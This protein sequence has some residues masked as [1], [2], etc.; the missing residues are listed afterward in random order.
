MT[1]PSII[2]LG[3]ALLAVASWLAIKVVLFD[4]LEYVCDIFQHL[5]ISRSVFQGHPFL[6]EPQAAGRL[7]NYPILPAFYAL[8]GWLG[9][10]GLFVGLAAWLTVAIAAVWRLASRAEAWRRDLYWTVLF[11]LGLGPVG[12]WLWDDPTYGWHTQLLFLPMGIL[13]AT[14]LIRGTRLAWIMAALIVLNREEGALVAWAIHAL[15]V[16]VP[17]APDDVAGQETRWFTPRTRRLMV[18]TSVYVV[19]F[20]VNFGWLLARQPDLGDSRLGLT[21]SHAPRSL[22]TDAA[23]RGAMGS[24][25]IDVALLLLSSWL[26]T[27]AGLRPRLS[28]AV[29][30]VGPL[31]ASGMVGML[32]YPADGGAMLYHGLSWPP[33]FVMVW[34]V[35]VAAFL[36]A[37]AAAAPPFTRSRAGHVALCAAVGLASVVAQDSVLESRRGYDAVSRVTTVAWRRS[38]L[39]SSVLTLREDAMLRCLG[40][41]LAADTPVKAPAFL[42]GRF[43]RQTPLADWRESQVVICDRAPGLRWPVPTACADRAAIEAATKNLVVDLLWIAYAPNLAPV[44]EACVPR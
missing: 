37:T 36:F 39:V 35:V 41:H 15:S 12:F 28:W 8:T 25:L 18:V 26:V 4:H 3:L 2:P 44:V 10:Y 40:A 29:L 7:H 5:A 13:F 16:L 1:R 22:L 30:L 34:T 6:W 27:L 31:V 42:D 33:R 17:P 9:A 19:A 23:T 38:T 14:C 20:G 21:V 32:A 43:H 24:A 11:T